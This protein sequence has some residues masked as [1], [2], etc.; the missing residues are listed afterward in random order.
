MAIVAERPFNTLTH[1]E[2]EAIKPGRRTLVHYTGRQPLPYH[3]K[4]GRGVPGEGHT[5][6]MGFTC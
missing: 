1:S 3:L 4:A 5:V 2:S 6:G